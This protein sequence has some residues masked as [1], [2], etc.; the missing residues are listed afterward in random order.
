MQKKGS[1]KKSRK[2]DWERLKRIKDEE[3]NLSESRELNE[4]DFAHVEVGTLISKI[5]VSIRLDQNV[6]DWFRG[7]GPGYQTRINDVLSRYIEET[8]LCKTKGAF[9]WRKAH[10]ESLHGGAKHNISQEMTSTETSNLG[11]LSVLNFAAYLDHLASVYSDYGEIKKAKTTCIL[12]LHFHAKALS[13]PE[14]HWKDVWQEMTTISEGML[15][16][17]SD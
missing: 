7:Q 15:S 3:I 16:E 13:T 2:T 4:E 9:I 14:D 12:A 8:E 10:R 1:D 5:P 17:L 6:L 11:P